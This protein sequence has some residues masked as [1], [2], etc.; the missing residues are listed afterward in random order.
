MSTS[1]FGGHFFDG[2]PGH[3]SKPKA[4]PAPGKPLKADGNNWDWRERYAGRL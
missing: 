2:T 1:I 3:R 4:V